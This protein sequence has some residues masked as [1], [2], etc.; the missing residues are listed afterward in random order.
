M[1]VVSQTWPVGRSSLTSGLIF[2]SLSVWAAVGHS[3]GHGP[4]LGR[5][6]SNTRVP[7]PARNNLFLSTT[8]L[9]SNIRH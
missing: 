2:D 9:E 6:S 4:D 3:E 8:K 1:S 7:W 5:E